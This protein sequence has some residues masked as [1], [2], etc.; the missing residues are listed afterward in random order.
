MSSLF[1]SGAGNK[2]FICMDR[3]YMVFLFALT[4]DELYSKIKKVKASLHKFNIEYY[5]EGERVTLQNDDETLKCLF[6]EAQQTGRFPEFFIDVDSHLPASN[7]SSYSVPSSQIQFQQD[8][9]FTTPPTSPNKSST[10]GAPSTP[11]QSKNPSSF[12]ISSIFSPNNPFASPPPVI[13]TKPQTPMIRSPSSSSSLSQRNN[14]FTNPLPSIQERISPGTNPFVS[15]QSTTSTQQTIPEFDVML[16]YSHTQKSNVDIIQ[17]KL[18]ER[19]VRVW[20]DVHL[21]PSYSNIYEA[22]GMGVF[23]SNCVIPCISKDYMGSSNCMGELRLAKDL[24]KPLAPVKFDQFPNPELPV[25]MRRQ[26]E[27]NFMI[28]GLFYVEMMNFLNLSDEE[29]NSKLALLYR[30]I[31][32]EYFNRNA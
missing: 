25:C 23:E 1:H 30:L 28:S 12:A 7:Y 32:S 13:Q 31:S 18:E 4:Y 19:H 17:R 20:R 22:I 16:S 26:I 10:F 5:V 15:P 29:R 14:P 2:A 27:T 11:I 8:G 6:I 3:K 9:P 24:K 21:M